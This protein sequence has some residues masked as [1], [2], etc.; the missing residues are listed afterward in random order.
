MSA[1]RNSRTA[2]VQ[3]RGFAT[4]SSLQIGPESPRFIDI[5]KIVQPSQSGRPNVKGT[6]PVPR[7]LFPSRRVD[8]PKKAYLDAATP[9]PKSERTVSIKSSNPAK[10]EWKHKMADLRRQ[11]L[12]EGLQDLY[13]RKRMA[14][15]TMFSRSRESRTRRDRI[16][17]QPEREDE[18]LTRSSTIQAMLPTKQS[19]LPD[20]NREERIALSQARL[21]AKQAEKKAVR[22]ADLQSLYMNA[23]TFIT[24]EEQLAAE[25]ERVFPE[26]E[27]VAWL[28]DHQPGENIWNLG[29]PSTV[30]SLVNQANKNEG[31]HWDVV[32]D[33]IKQLGEQITGGKM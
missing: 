20:P 1:L 19:V 33:R 2:T 13:A 27:N 14:E 4:S 24:T 23:R 18:R 25:I 6:L 12:R 17:Q 7:E 15:G 29:S 11:N 3:V 5:P 26:G 10:Q 21:E 28:N 22:K 16:F 9:L 31:A 30:N 32:Q 8:K